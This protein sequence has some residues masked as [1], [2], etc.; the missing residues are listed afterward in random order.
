MRAV[1]EAIQVPWVCHCI[2]DLLS[3]WHLKNQLDALVIVLKCSL[4]EDLISFKLFMDLEW[5]RLFW[6]YACKV[7]ASKFV[8]REIKYVTAWKGI[9]LCVICNLFLIIT[10]PKTEI[11]RKKTEKSL[12]TF[13]K[14]GFQLEYRPHISWDQFFFWIRYGTFSCPSI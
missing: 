11:T 12:E 5:Q 10:F 1:A 4:S 6:F 3:Y 7:L 2:L 14:L 8:K 9:W 13:Y